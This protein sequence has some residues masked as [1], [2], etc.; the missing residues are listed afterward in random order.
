MRNKVVM[1]IGAAVLATPMMIKPSAAA[2]GAA[3]AGLS[4]AADQLIATENAQYSWGGRRYCW[5]D[6][7]WSG[8]GF[9]WCGYSWRRGLGWGGPV[10][11]RGWG[12]SGFRGPGRPGIGRPGF[13]PGR[14]GFGAGRPGGRPGMGGRPGGR[15]GGVGGRPG[16]RP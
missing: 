4:D 3:P 1:L 14:P 9:Y 13:G 2:V 16:G 15:P 12:H 11:W 6:D 7:G 8:P 5:Y 10:G